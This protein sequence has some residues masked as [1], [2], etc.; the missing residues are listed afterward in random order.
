[1]KDID[2]IAWGEDLLLG[3]SLIVRSLNFYTLEIM[4]E[5]GFQKWTVIKEKNRF[6]HT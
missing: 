1:M 3:R 6:I 4:N 5:E 2:R